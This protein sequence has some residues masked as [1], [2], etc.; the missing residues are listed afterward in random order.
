MTDERSIE[1][2]GVPSGTPGRTTWKQ[3]FCGFAY[4]HF[5]YSLFSLL[6]VLVWIVVGRV[7]ENLENGYFILDGLMWVEGILSMVLYFPLG[8]LETKWEK[9]T[10]PTGKEV[11]L[12]VI[13]PCLVSIPWAGTVLIGMGVEAWGI[14]A[15]CLGPISFMLAGPSSYFVA[16]FSTRLPGS[17]FENVVIAGLLAAVLPPL[18]FAFGSW[19]QAKRQCASSEGKGDGTVVSS[20]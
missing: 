1:R 19:W 18:L 10:A 5:A 6:F 20:S 8:M 17:G 3:R 7:T 2:A 11:L 14:L 9:W 12:A 4:C 16:F 13:L 15:L